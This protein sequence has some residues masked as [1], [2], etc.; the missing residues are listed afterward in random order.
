MGWIGRSSVSRNSSSPVAPSASAF[1]ATAV[2]SP[3][4]MTARRTSA[5]GISDA[6]ATASTMTPSSAPCRSPPSSRPVRNRCSCSVARENSVASSSRRFACEPGPEVAAM[7]DIAASTSSSAS[8]GVVAGSGRS[9]S[10]AQPTPIEPCG[11]TPERYATAT[12]PRRCP[13]PRSTRRAAPPSRGEKTFRRRRPTSLRSRRAASAS[14]K[15]M[16]IEIQTSAPPP[17]RAASVR[18]TAVSHR[19]RL[20]DREPEARSTSCTRRIFTTEALE[21]AG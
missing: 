7:R 16:G 11:N 4:S 17:A 21:R 9:R 13:Q 12:P 14:F 15:L 20:G 18:P 8:V 6:L 1:V 5:T 19:H 3:A 2:R 10:A